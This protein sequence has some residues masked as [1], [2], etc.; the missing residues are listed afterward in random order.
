[1]VNRQEEFF[2]LLIIHGDDN[3]DDDVDN[4]DGFYDKDDAD[5]NDD[6]DG[7]DDGDGDD[8]VRVSTILFLTNPFRIM[9]LFTIIHLEL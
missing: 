9:F 6:D 4:G 8:D 3:D 1:M 7:D 5:D 2:Q